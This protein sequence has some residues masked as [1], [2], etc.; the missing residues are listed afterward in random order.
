MASERAGLPNAEDLGSR[1]TT[2]RDDG[3]VVVLV[4]LPSPQDLG[5]EQDRRGDDQENDDF[6]PPHVPSSSYPSATTRLAATALGS[7]LWSGSAQCVRWR[8][9]SSSCQSTTS[10]GG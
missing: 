4:L 1:P 9:S 10:S 7:G 6:G 8:G 2:P 3:F 5:E